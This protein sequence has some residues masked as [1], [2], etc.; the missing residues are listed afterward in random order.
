MFKT[1]IRIFKTN[2][3]ISINFLLVVELLLHHT[4]FLYS[5]SFILFYVKHNN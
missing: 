2:N 1:I 5:G 3:N 4:K